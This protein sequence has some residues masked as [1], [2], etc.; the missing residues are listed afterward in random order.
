MIHYGNGLG[1]ANGEVMA[2]ILMQYK[3]PGVKELTDSTFEHL[4]QVFM[5]LSVSLCPGSRSIPT[6]PLNILHRY[7][8]LVS[9]CLCPGSRSIPTTPP[10]ILHRYS[11][12]CLSVLG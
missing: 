9:V 11:C 10:N 3:E 1:P 4:T 2:E 6:A 5:P 12:L 7:S 8:C